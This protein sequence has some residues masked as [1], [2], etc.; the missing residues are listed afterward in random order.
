[1]LVACGKGLF[2]V[3]GMVSSPPTFRERGG[4]WALVQS[5]L[6]IA[7]CV[8]VF[9]DQGSFGGSWV[10]VVG[11]ALFGL[12]SIAGVGGA[13]SLR[14]NRTIFP[15]PKEDSRLITGG[16]YR[17]VRHPLYASLMALGSG[18]ALLRGSWTAL[19]ITLV[20]I[21]FLRFKAAREETWLTERFPDYVDYARRVARFIPGAW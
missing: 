16:I 15:R 18:W 6:M 21:V 3:S 9:I 12:G 2:A 20:M 11:W 17:W 8:A 13:L 14:S 7:V 19:G 5:V 10:T 1:M 4:G